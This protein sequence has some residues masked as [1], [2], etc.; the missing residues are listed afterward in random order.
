MSQGYFLLTIHHVQNDEFASLNQYQVLVV[1]QV[2]VPL[3]IS[4]H[5][6]LVSA[7]TNSSKTVYGQSRTGCDNQSVHSACCCSQ[8][9]QPPWAPF[10]MRRRARSGEHQSPVC[11]CSKLRVVSLLAGFRK[12]SVLKFYGMLMMDLWEQWHKDL[13]N[14]IGCLAPKPH[15]ICNSV[16]TFSVC[17]LHCALVSCAPI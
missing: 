12:I 3:A 16:H 8:H 4:R 13:C 7:L 10:S 5:L 6:V 15:E 9:D 17:I 2:L 11:F 14:D 1:A